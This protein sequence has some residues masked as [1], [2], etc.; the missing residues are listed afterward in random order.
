MAEYNPFKNFNPAFTRY[1]YLE[2]ITVE[3]SLYGNIKLPQDYNLN[4]D[5]I[6]IAPH[7]ITTSNESTKEDYSM[8]DS[9]G[10][11]HYETIIPSDNSNF[12]GGS[13][14]DNE[15]FAYEYLVKNK[16][17]KGAA[18]GI[19]G[20]LYHEGLSNPTKSNK[21]SRDTTSY[22]IAQFNSDGEMKNLMKW[23]EKKKI[24]GLPNFQ[25]QLD[26]IIDVIKERPNLSLLLN[27]NITPEE[28][29]FIWGSQF[30]RFA[31]DNNK[32]GFKNRKDSNHVKRAKRAN[33]ILKSYG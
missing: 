1:E 14:I 5:G 31:G 6:W 12:E 7:N 9:L 30:E 2:P 15:R 3:D 33:K 26:F 18:A 28:A 22:G 16:I 20:N 25:Q 17:P 23:A 13:L 8:M 32:D 24:S 4:S 10:N 21:D 27:N 29:S 11:T 19:V